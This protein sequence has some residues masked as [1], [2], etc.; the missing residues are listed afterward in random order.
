[1][2]KSPTDGE[3]IMIILGKRKKDKSFIDFKLER[4]LNINTRNYLTD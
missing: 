4:L 3:I 2:L 1:M